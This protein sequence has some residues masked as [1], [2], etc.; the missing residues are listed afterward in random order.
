MCRYAPGEKLRVEHL[1]DIYQVSAGTLRETCIATVQVPAL[2]RVRLRTAEDG[3]RQETK[4]QAAGTALM[5]TSIIPL[6]S[7]VG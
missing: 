6:T 7:R 4:I 3:H 1:K 5:S 2:D